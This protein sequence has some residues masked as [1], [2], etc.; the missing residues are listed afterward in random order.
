LCFKLITFI[1]PRIR[2]I[3]FL[4][5][6]TY[7]QSSA[8]GLKFSGKPYERMLSQNVEAECSS[9]TKSI[10][11]TN[12]LFSQTSFMYVKPPRI[13]ISE[14]SHCLLAGSSFFSWADVTP[15][16][17]DPLYLIVLAFPRMLMQYMFTKCS[18]LLCFV[19][20]GL[21]KYGLYSK[22]HQVTSLSYYSL[23]L[24][25]GEEGGAPY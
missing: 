5:F 8:V 21:L 19:Y 18:V 6:G 10:W 20:R 15:P 13:T 23:A 4:S 2:K 25:G 12:Y 24:S 22:N 1:S 7:E 11:L 16:Y 9:H 14:R 17:S 3:K